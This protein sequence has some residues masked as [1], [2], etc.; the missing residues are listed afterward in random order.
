M[1]IF[2]RI[3]FLCLTLA[4]ATLPALRALAD[5]EF[6]V[7]SVYKPLS[8]GDPGEVSVKDYFI[9]MGTKDGIHNGSVVEVVRRTSTYDLTSQKLYKDV[10]FPIA[11]LKVI[12]AE[13]NAAIARLS[14]IF[15]PEKTPA[16]LPRAVMVGDLVKNGE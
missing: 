13:P 6:I 9:N 10:S 4:A 8:L 7:Y 3:L 16:I 15:S 1:Q 12:H 5:D 2:R 11:K 14:E